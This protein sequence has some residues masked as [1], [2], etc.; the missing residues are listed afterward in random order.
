MQS[1]LP[2]KVILRAMLRAAARLPSRPSYRPVDR[3]IRRYYAAEVE[4][5]TG[6]EPDTSNIEDPLFPFKDKRIPKE[7]VPGGLWF[8]SI[9]DYIKEEE[10]PRQRPFRSLVLDPRQIDAARK[11][12]FETRWELFKKNFEKETLRKYQAVWTKKN[13]E[14]APVVRELLKNNRAEWK[15]YR[16]EMLDMKERMRPK[17]G[18]KS[19][20]LR[21]LA[22]PDKRPLELEQ[23][24][25]RFAFDFVR[26]KVERYIETHATFSQAYVEGMLSLDEF[27]FEREL[28][29]DEEE[30][31][32]ELSQKGVDYLQ[33][34]YDGRKDSE[35]TSFEQWC[36]RK[37]YAI[38]SFIYVASLLKE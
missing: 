9:K 14:F 35:K 23:I 33:Q 30:E 20:D 5:E 2:V 38:I 6:P 31:L 32:A 21:A 28:M 11:S 17:Q 18:F 26:E 36:K 22:Y 37:W 10:A 27:N 25:N 1:Q 3:R 19:E 16:G 24:T 7:P 8:T 13:Q 4:E 15:E 29:E 34:W 12:L